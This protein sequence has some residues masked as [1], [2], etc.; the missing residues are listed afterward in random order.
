M[1]QQCF[2]GERFSYH[3]KRYQFEDVKITPGYVQQGGP[4]L[5]IAAMSEAGALRAAHYNTNFLPQGVKAES[6]DP[7]V[8]ALQDSGRNPMIIELALFVAFWSPTTKPT[9]GTSARV[10]ALSQQL[11]RQCMR[12]A[13]RVLGVKENRYRKPGLLAMLNTASPSLNTSFKLLVLPTSYQWCRR[14]CAPVT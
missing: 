8:N 14:E 4:P 1:L 13:A 7:W 10:R 9:L 12:K 6:Y 5:W 2:S 3:G 11:Y